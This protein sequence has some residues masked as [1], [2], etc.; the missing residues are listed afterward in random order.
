MAGLPDW[1][2]VP[3]GYGPLVV[4]LFRS[5]EEILT[6]GA[7]GRMPGLAAVQSTGI[8]T[9]AHGVGVSQGH[10]LSVNPLHE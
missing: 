7:T 6:S 1:V 2:L 9:G 3:V 4:G 10:D 8:R 5:F